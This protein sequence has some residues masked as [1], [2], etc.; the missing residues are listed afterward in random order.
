[1]QNKPV[2]AAAT[3]LYEDAVAGIES[4]SIRKWATSDHNKPLW[5]QICQNAI[6]N[7][8]RDPDT[9]CAYMVATAIGL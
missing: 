4:E 6:D 5:L 7:G 3:K 2:S 1:M 9:M 8:K